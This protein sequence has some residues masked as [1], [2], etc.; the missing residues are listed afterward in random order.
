M[1][2]I[3]SHLVRTQTFVSFILVA[4][5]CG[6]STS[7]VLTGTL[8]VRPSF[9]AA[10]F[11][12]PELSSVAPVPGGRYEAPRPTVKFGIA[13]AY[14]VNRRVNISLGFEYNRMTMKYFVDPNSNPG[15]Y[16]NWQVSFL[17]I[18]VTCEYSLPMHWG[19][20]TPVIA[21]G[22]GY[23][24]GAMELNL[25][26]AE[27]SG[28]PQSFSSG[29]RHPRPWAITGRVGLTTRQLTDLGLSLAFEFWRTADIHPMTVR[30]PDNQTEIIGM[31]F[32]GIAVSISAQ[33]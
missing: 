26:Y 25:N 4:V 10:F 31:Y 13:L 17:P 33:M 20:V 24:V 15:L 3:P 9:G 12:F 28:G 14:W 23:E 2:P 5:L 21:I 8:E 29:G 1:K 30:R 19:I 11:D 32:T 16:A 18:L 7:Q 6:Q 22:A 27:S